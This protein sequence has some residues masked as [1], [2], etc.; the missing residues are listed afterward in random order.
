LHLDRFHIASQTNPANKD[1]IR[2][3]KIAPNECEYDQR[4]VM[5]TTVYSPPTETTQSN[6]RMNIPESHICSNS[7][8]SKNAIIAADI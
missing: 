6:P 1:A 5:K 8:R 7:C 4:R 3:I 2:N